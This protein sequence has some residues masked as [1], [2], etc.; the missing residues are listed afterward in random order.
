MAQVVTSIIC[1]QC[2]TLFPS[3][4]R[5]IRILEHTDN[6]DLVHYAEGTTPL[7]TDLAACS[8][9]CASKLLSKRMEA[10]FRLPK[11]KEEVENVN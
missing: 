7:S 2:R 11:T 3:Q 6:A 1:D 9:G 10:R 8:L 5:Y 4:D